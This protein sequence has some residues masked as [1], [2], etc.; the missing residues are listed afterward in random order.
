MKNV[1]EMGQNDSLSL[2]DASRACNMDIIDRVTQVICFAFHDSN[3][4]LETCNEAK[5]MRKIVTLFYLD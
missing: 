5:R 4:M 3:L 1:V 2:F